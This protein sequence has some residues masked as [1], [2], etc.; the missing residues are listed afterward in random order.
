MRRKGT[1]AF[2]EIYQG[3]NHQTTSPF[4]IY[5][6]S[7]CAQAF[8]GPHSPTLPHQPPLF[9]RPTT[10]QVPTLARPWPATPHHQPAQP[11][12]ETPAATPHNP[13]PV[14]GGGVLLEGTHLLEEALHHGL[15]LQ[16]LV[17]TQR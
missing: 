1:W 5:N 9:R 4:N 16:R 8:P 6:S 11:A 3:H 12:G 13:G 10:S 2:L 14:G 15:A 17:F 7:Y